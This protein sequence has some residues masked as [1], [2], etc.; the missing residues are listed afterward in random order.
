MSLALGG[1]L[2]RTE[3]AS[4]QLPVWSES[5]ASWGGGWVELAPR[6]GTTATQI[7]VFLVLLISIQLNK[8]STKRSVFL[9]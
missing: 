9:F 6:G 3:T 5:L 2:S 4:V 8:N 7:F 1:L